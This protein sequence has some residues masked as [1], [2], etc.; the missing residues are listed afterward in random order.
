MKLVKL[1]NVP[2]KNEIISWLIKLLK[3]SESNYSPL[4]EENNYP[5]KE[6][7]ILING[8]KIIP[9]YIEC[10]KD[11][12]LV[13][14]VHESC[15]KQGYAK[16]MINKMG[17]KYAIAAPDSIQFWKTMGFNQISSSS[18]PAIMKRI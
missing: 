2:N 17:I 8:D 12:A 3:E 15:R 9:A 18:G 7:F 6:F 13:L 4:I 14:W 16:F 1:K 10:K 11:E 5:N